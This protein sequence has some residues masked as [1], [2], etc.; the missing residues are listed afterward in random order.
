M[1]TIKVQCP[2][3]KKSYNAQESMVDKV[4]K[5]LGC[6]AP[7]KISS[8]KGESN[9]PEDKP[10]K[11][12][13]VQAIA[14]SSLILLC[15]IGVSGLIYAIVTK[16]D[17][18]KAYAQRLEAEEIQKKED[19]KRAKEAAVALAKAEVEKRKKDEDDRIAKEEKEILRQLEIEEANKPFTI[20][21]KNSNSFTLDSDQFQVNL[22][23]FMF[24]DK[25]FINS[26]TKAR[27]DVVIYSILIQNKTANKNIRV[28]L[29]FKLLKINKQ[30]LFDIETVDEFGNRFGLSESG[31]EGFSGTQTVLLGPG[32]SFATK[33]NGGPI[34]K[35]AKRLF[36]KVSLPDGK[37]GK[38][39]IALDQL[40]R[41][42]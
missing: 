41:V 24:D 39:E 4:V 32:E 6:A 21:G 29:P 25:N 34:V 14:L 42:P 31:K 18:D 37:I 35:T 8:G 11:K 17:R 30:D 5:C 40:P 13:P 10:N 19:E 28:D 16:P 20:D 26:K 22:N 7:F 9:S 23:S 36:V 38:F 33:A 2:Q 1:P 12:L 27:F 15:A 3:C